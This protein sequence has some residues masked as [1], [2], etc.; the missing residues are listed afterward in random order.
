M[1]DLFEDEAGNS[2][3]EDHFNR[4]KDHLS[5]GSFTIAW[6]DGSL[7]L[8][9]GEVSTMEITSGGYATD[10]N[11]G[12]TSPTAEAAASSTAQSEFE[13]QVGY[14]LRS[15]TTVETKSNDVINMYYH[16][17]VGIIAFS[18]S[19]KGDDLCQFDQYFPSGEYGWPA[20]YN[21]PKQHDYIRS[22]DYD[23]NPRWS[24]SG[25]FHA[26]SATVLGAGTVT[27]TMIA[28][29][30]SPVTPS[31]QTVSLSYP[32]LITG[33]LPI[34]KPSLAI[35]MMS[36]PIAAAVDALDGLSNALEDA[37]DAMNNFWRTR[38]SQK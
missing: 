12:P 6:G 4:T 9:E 31:S 24:N 20:I 35:R 17:D 36:A 29:L 13:S 19:A 34:E 10:A 21:E 11:T 26:Y 5:A 23:P 38:R 7:I 8:T 22:E 15:W 18:G 37:A 2:D 14:P 32:P 33:T 27:S 1:S 28:N 16:R 3:L 25:Q 30:T